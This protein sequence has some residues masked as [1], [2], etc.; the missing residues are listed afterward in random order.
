MKNL[1]ATPYILSAFLAISLTSCEKEKSLDETILGK[2]EVTTMTQITYEN[3]VKKSEVI[4][5]LEAGEMA[6]QFVDSGSGIYSEGEDEALFS[7]SIAGSVLT[8]SNLFEG[9]ALVVDVTLEGDRLSWFNTKPDAQ[10]ANITYDYIMT[11]KRI[12]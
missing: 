7:W 8:I 6:Y 4:V 2:W 11:A 5:Y 3:N 1:K 9:G 10:N 12:S